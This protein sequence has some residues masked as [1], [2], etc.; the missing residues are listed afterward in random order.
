[1]VDL[2]DFPK[3][4]N[5]KDGRELIIRNIEKTDEAE[6][7]R[8]MKDLPPDERIYFR[9]DVT[10]PE[11]IHRWVHEID[12]TKVV[13]LIGLT[14]ERIVANWSLH[15]SDQFWTR[16][17]IHIRGIVGPEF[18]GH[19]IAAKMVF[20]LLTIA[21]DLG[22]ER[23]VIELVAQQKRL[24]S[25]FTAIGFKLEAVLKGWV[26]DHTGNYNDLLILTMELEPAWKKM[27]E[28]IW[29]YGTHGG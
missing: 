29:T 17:M 21:G 5:I 8:F 28:M 12:F 25:R 24:L 11:V 20:E 10:D 13:P 7:I 15:L 18:R 2:S 9:D 23:V 19:G 22:I 27:E 14:E 3:V 16:H 26:K 6:L 4:S 1:M